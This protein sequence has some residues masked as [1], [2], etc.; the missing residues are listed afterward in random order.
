[1]APARPR[2][3]RAE[4][5]PLVREGLTR[6]EVEEL[7]GGPPGNYGRYSTRSG[8]MTTEGSFGPPGSVE[9]VWCGD[10]NQFEVYFGPPRACGPPPQAG[11]YYQTLATFWLQLRL[12]LGL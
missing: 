7:L 12:R 9:E 2:G 1:V 8:W 4:N 6:A 10:G 11:R 5:Y 3:L